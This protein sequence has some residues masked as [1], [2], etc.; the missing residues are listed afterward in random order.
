MTVAE[1]L[2]QCMRAAHTIADDRADVSILSSRTRFTPSIP[3]VASAV[4][5]ARPAEM[6]FIL[7]RFV[8][9]FTKISPSILRNCGGND[10]ALPNGAVQK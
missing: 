4:T 3:T 2:A 7:S 5:I 10:P 8:N 6:D 9:Y 1:L